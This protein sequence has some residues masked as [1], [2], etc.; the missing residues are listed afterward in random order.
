M[1]TNQF[2]KQLSLT[3]RNALFVREWERKNLPIEQSF[4]ALDL[5][6]LISHHTLIDKPLTLKLLC[7]S[8]YSSETGIRKHLRRFINDEW[9]VLIG[10]DRDR[11]IRH[12][13]ALP[14]M[15]DTLSAYSQVLSVSYSQIKK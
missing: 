8:V 10:C 6:L 13:I 4:L 15:L 9:C 14:K 5:F 12:I 3:T 2:Q 11:R 1:R 7:N